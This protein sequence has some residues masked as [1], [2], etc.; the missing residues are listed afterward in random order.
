MAILIGKS[1]ENSRKK[2]S[3]LAESPSDFSGMAVATF[4]INVGGKT[5]YIP[6]VQGYK[7]SDTVT[8]SNS[9]EFKLKDNA[10]IPVWAKTDLLALVDRSYRAINTTD[11][12]GKG[13]GDPDSNWF[14]VAHVS[15]DI[16]DPSYST[17][18]TNI[19]LMKVKASY[20]ASVKRTITTYNILPPPKYVVTVRVK[21]S[22]EER[23]VKDQYQNTHYYTDYVTSIPQVSSN[24]VVDKPLTIQISYNNKSSQ[25]RPY[26]EPLVTSDPVSNSIDFPAYSNLVKS[27]LGFA[28]KLI[29]EY[30]RSRLYRDEKYTISI[31]LAGITK[32]QTVNMFDRVE[33]VDVPFEFDLASLI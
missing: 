20:T 13:N 16:G 15:L 12:I 18:F 32:T 2:K 14:N 4:G 3:I 22:T 23:S 17:K 11:A 10:A 7:G 19:L 28:R 21:K 33:T 31:S 1:F 5:Y 30:D 29:S 26:Q 9:K 27:E 8:V 6:L 25:E 24:L